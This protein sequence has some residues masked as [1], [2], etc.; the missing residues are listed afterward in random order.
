MLQNLLFLPHYQSDHKET[1]LVDECVA[2][3]DKHNLK[4]KT[5]HDGEVIIVEFD[6]GIGREREKE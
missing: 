1:K 5:L 2:Y 6:K 3:C 4:Y